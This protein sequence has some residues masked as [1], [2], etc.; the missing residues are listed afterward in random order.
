MYALY[1]L[2]FSGILQIAIAKHPED[3]E[4]LFL[5]PEHLQA[6]G[7]ETNEGVLPYNGRSFT[8]YRL[9]TEFF[10]FP[11]KFL[12]LEL[13]G[14]TAENLRKIGDTLEIFFYLQSTNKDL[15]PHISASNFALGCTPM[16]NLFKHRAE[17]ISLKQTESEYRIIPDVRRP[18]HFEI[19]S[20]QN[21]TAVNSE[22][23]QVTYRPFYGINHGAARDETNCYWY[24]SRRP[25]EAQDGEYV[26]GTEL[27]LSLVDL[28]FKTSDLA[29][30]ALDIETLACNRDLPAALPFG[31]G[32]P[33]LQFATF[34]APV[35]KILCLTPPTPT[36][37]IYGREEGLWRL[38]S[39]LTLNHLSLTDKEEG[40]EA[41]RE[42]LHLYDYVE[43]DETQAL[44]EAIVSLSSNK[45]L[46][47]DPSGSLN[48]FCQG[49]EMIIEFDERRFTGTS[50]FLFA[51][52]LDRFLAL[53]ASVNAFTKLTA[54]TKGR[55][56]VIHKWSARIGDKNLL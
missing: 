48:G 24:V 28:N 54:V 56:R 44:I 14:L 31:G 26:T 46:A 35:S 45:V 34:S 42:I 25:A 40:A 13:K 36:R 3:K 18:K 50:L 29:D 2:L 7:F 17:P 41:L 51:S 47:R 39:H 5:S 19:Y 23:E 9:L 49:Q 16:V 22:G 33:Y 20:I 12:F 55:R 6:V 37:R 21:I 38:I 4:A 10:A 52:V 15:E 8:G 1:E 27:F 53:Y 43:N 30:W 11:E 32:E